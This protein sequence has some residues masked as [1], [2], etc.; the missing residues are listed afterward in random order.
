MKGFLPMFMSGT[1]VKHTYIQK[2][3]M[4]VEENPVKKWFGGMG[5]GKE[6]Q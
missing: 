6:K 5:G 1:L 2:R 4:E 3:N